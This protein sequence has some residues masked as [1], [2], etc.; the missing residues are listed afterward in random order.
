MIACIVIVAVTLLG[1]IVTSI[2]KPSIKIK[3][4]T[5]NLYWVIALLGALILL[6]STVLPMGGFWNG[7]TSNEGM[8]P[9]KILV[10]FLSMTGI[11]IYLDEVGFFSYLANVVVKHNKK[12]Q[13]R[14][15]IA[16]YVLIAILTMFTSNDIV[17]L[18][19]TPFIILF[20]KR[21]GISPIP[22]LVA[23]FV[24]AN[25]WSMMFIIGNPTNIY[26]ASTYNI[27]FVDYFLTMGVPTLLAG[28]VEFAILILLFFKQL[29]QPIQKANI[30]KVEMEKFHLIYGISILVL[31]IV[32]LVLS[33]YVNIEMWIISLAAFVVLMIG[34][35][36]ESL[37]EKE[38]LLQVRHTLK[39]L[40][41]ELIPFLLSM[42]AIVLAL[43]QYDV[44]THIHNFFGSNMTNVIYGYSSLLSAN[45]V[46]NIPMSIA[47]SNIIKGLEGSA[48]KGA[49][50]GSIIGSNIGA[51]ITPLGALAGLMWMS[52]LKKYEVHYNFASFIKYG[53]II[54]I[55]TATVAIFSLMLFIQ[56]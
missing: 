34:I 2:V 55:P 39:R 43:Q 11:S 23:E 8:N 20:A 24:C 9:L 35:I 25:T 31:C 14:L 54:G 40:P 4:F 28:L 15:F 30:E 41:Y 10:L 45:L 29:K 52:I 32:F 12:S 27:I 46:N 49:L 1:I 7:L 19:F 50:Y 17:I 42:F 38:S 51:F 5:L 33:N 26:I 53:V 21:S 47:F 56:N 37:L 22:Y 44:L 6:L 3:S 16:L 13:I 48:L 36:T 18:T